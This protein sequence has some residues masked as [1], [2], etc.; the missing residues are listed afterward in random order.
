MLIIVRRSQRR[1]APAQ[2]MIRADLRQNESEPALP[3][4]I[5]QWLANFCKQ[6]FCRETPAFESAVRWR[7]PA[8]FF[9]SFSIRKSARGEAVALA[10]VFPQQPMLQDLVIR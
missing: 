5:I 6:T 9:R 3:S 1:A 8:H 4:R 2:P 10:P 7:L